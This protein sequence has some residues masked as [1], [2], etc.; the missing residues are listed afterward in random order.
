MVALFRDIRTNEPCA[1]HRTFLHGAGRKLDRKMLGR[2]AAGVH[3]RIVAVR[4]GAQ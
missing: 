4:T 2:V 1:I 3:S